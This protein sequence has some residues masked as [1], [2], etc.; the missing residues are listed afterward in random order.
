[1]VPAILQEDLIR[2]RPTPLRIL[3]GDA[4]EVITF[5]QSRISL[6]QS[7]IDLL[8]G[9]GG[10]LRMGGA[11]NHLYFDAAGE[12]YRLL[13]RRHGASIEFLRDALKGCRL[14]AEAL[15]QGVLGHAQAIKEVLIVLKGKELPF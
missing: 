8:A 2:G 3:F 11:R 15:P 14:L 5:P 13:R 9:L 6:L 7:E 12:E 1:M 10:V 4:D